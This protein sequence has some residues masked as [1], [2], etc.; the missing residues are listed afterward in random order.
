MSAAWDLVGAQPARRGGA[1]KIPVILALKALRKRSSTK[2]ATLAT[3]GLA[4]L[5]INLMAGCGKADTNPKAANAD[6]SRSYSIHF[7]DNI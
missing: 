5:T 3:I 6:E 1:A 2:L 7:K 4:S